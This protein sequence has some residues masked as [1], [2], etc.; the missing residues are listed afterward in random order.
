[1]LFR[2]LSA[3]SIKRFAPN[4]PITLFTDRADHPLCALGVFDRVEPIGAVTGF[5][6]AWA[7]GQLGRIQALSRSPY[8]ITLNL[9][10]DTR[11]RSPEIAS[12][13]AELGDADVG[14]VEEAVDV[15]VSR[16]Q[17]G[18]RMFNVGFI[19]YRRE[20]PILR[21]LEAW[22]TRVRRNFGFAL[23]SPLPFVAE[24]AHVR[25]EEVRRQ[26]LRIDQVALMEILSPDRNELGLRLKQ[27]ENAW[28]YRGSVVAP[29]PPDRIRISHLD[30]FK[31]TTHADILTLAEACAA[32][33]PRLS[34]ALYEYVASRQNVVLPRPRRLGWFKKAPAGPIAERWST[35]QFESRLVNPSNR[36]KLDVIIVGTGLAGASAAATMGEEIGRAHV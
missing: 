7:E 31:A 1:M 2:S 19:L 29:C 17:T 21:L 16:S 30:E 6:S 35:R 24:L 12:V 9:D 32:D 3:Q 20:E 4:L 33:S 18:R 22:E 26:L 36:R 15:S 28:N 5:E 10:T 8:A 34:D 23:E 27:L 11:V 13:F 25:D 14:L